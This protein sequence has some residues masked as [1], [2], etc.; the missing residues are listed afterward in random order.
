MLAE[1]S[2]LGDFGYGVGD[3]LGF[4]AVSE[5]VEGQAGADGAGPDAWVREVVVVVGGGA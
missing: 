2:A 3:E 1:S 5:A 4:V